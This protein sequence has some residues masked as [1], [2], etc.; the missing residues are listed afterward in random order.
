M[1]SQQGS[2]PSVAALYEGVVQALN[3]ECDNGE[4]VGD[5]RWGIYLFY[6]YDGEPNLCRANE[7]EASRPHLGGT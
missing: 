4:K 3:A 1:P 6:D 2:P 5:C 7:R